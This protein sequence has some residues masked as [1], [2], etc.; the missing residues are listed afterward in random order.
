MNPGAALDACGGGD[1]DCDGLVDEDCAGGGDTGD[2]GD[3]GEDSGG[4]TESGTSDSGTSDSGAAGADT[5]S[6]DPDAKPDYEAAD[7]SVLSQGG[8]GCAG[9]GGGLAGLAGLGVSALG[10]LRRRR[11]A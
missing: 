9:G 8:C 4:D 1:A 10:L 5:G 7:P 11:S 2:T 6:T 3:T